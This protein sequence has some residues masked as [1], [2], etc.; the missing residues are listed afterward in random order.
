MSAIYCHEFIVPTA[1]VD[2]NGHVNNVEYV[3]WM[4]EVAVMHS[5]FA[6]CTQATRA[7]GVTWVARS[8]RI[9]YLRPAFAGDHMAVLTWVTNFRKVRSLRKYKFTRTTDNAVIAE[10][11]TDWVFVDAKTGRPKSVPK[12]VSSA[13]ELIPYERERS[14]GSDQDPPA[15]G[16]PAV[17][18]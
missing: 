4:Q 2:E 13:F 17:R 12:E 18:L 5:D 10:G 15:T 7:A 9:E 11:E 16:A 3:K 6:G 1:S 8:H 14:G